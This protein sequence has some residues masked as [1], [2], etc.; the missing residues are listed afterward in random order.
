MVILGP[1]IVAIPVDEDG[2]CSQPNVKTDRH[3]PNETFLVD[4]ALIARNVNRV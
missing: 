4:D 3:V 2:N 1:I